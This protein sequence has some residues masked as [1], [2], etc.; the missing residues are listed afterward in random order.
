[1]A[2]SDAVAVASLSN[3]LG[4]P[5]TAGRIRERFHRAVRDAD[6]IVLVAAEGSGGVAGWIHV[7]GRHLLESEPFAEIVGLVVDAKARRKGV[8]LALVRAAEAWATQQG[9]EAVRVR[10][11]R[12]R[13]EAPGFYRSIGYEVMKA[14]NVFNRSLK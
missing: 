2:V 10:S 12:L 9:Y 4:Y 11:N 3:E 6:G 13:A 7:Q 5:S 8:G 1:M 14:Q